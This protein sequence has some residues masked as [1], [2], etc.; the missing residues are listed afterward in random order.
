MPNKHSISKLLPKGRAF[1][2]VFLSIAAA[3][4]FVCV[5]WALW[6]LTSQALDDYGNWYAQ[7][8][9]ASR[10][11]AWLALNL[12]FGGAIWMAFGRPTGERA[13]ELPTREG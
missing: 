8:S 10:I 6:L 5:E 13:S 9:V 2:R 4:A 7:D 3:A 11:G 1:L 12:G